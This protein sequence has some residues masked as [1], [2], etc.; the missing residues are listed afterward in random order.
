RPLPEAFG[1]L[2]RLYARTRQYD[3]QADVLEQLAGLAQDAE[4]RRGFLVR[5]AQLL[6]REGGAEEAVGAW[7]RLLELDA[8]DSAAVAGLERL[9][10]EDALRGEV[11]RLLE[12]VYRSLND[13][14][15][16]VEVL[17]L[18]LLQAAPSERLARLEEVATLREALGQKQLAFAARLRALR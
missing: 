18:R 11:A 5:R 4:A 9:L 10:T 13:V 2:E 3:A 12:P 8:R 7:A 15:K 17:D 1:S 6:E 14:K 16:L